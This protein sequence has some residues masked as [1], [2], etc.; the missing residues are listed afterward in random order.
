MRASTFLALALSSLAAAQKTIIDIGT[1]TVITLS[2]RPT[3]TFDPTLT[4]STLTT[5][6]TTTTTPTTC[7]TTYTLFSTATQWALSTRTVTTLTSST[8]T[9]TSTTTSTVSV[10]QPTSTGVHYDYCPYPGWPISVID[11]EYRP[12]WPDISDYRGLKWVNWA[13]FNYYPG[14]PDGWAPIPSN[15]TT[16]FTKTGGKETELWIASGPRA[17]LTGVHSFWFYY[18]EPKIAPGI[19]STIV[20]EG[21]S[22][23]SLVHATKI[24]TEVYE[25]GIWEHVCLDWQKFDAF[26]IILPDCISSNGCPGAWFE[27]DDIWVRGRGK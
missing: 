6:P 5:K 17:K 22:G 3:L 11:F 24:K 1:A 16:G 26:R 14:Y 13:G 2:T 19:Y 20:L 9:T 18:Y 12:N 7:N 10:P 15:Y 27:V 23:G 8:V 21:Y 25:D 4:L